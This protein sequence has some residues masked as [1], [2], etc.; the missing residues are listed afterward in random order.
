M[1][2]A[3]SVDVAGCGSGM[4]DGRLMAWS[5]PGTLFLPPIFLIEFSLFYSILLP[6]LRTCRTLV[7]CS[8]RLVRTPYLHLVEEG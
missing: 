6:P 7:E 2:I 3:G 4:S 1:P 8:H 5:F